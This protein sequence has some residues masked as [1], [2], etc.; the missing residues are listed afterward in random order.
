MATTKTN[1]INLPT[2]I[3]LPDAASQTGLSVDKLTRLVEAGRIAA[4]Q[5]PD[6]EI[7]VS[8]RDTD[9]AVPTPKE[10]L[11]EYKKH[12]HLR[13][14]VIGIGEA[15]RRHEIPQPTISRWVKLGYIQK[16]GQQ[17]QKLLIDAADAAYC[18]E[19]Y[20]VRGGGQG[21]WLFNSDGT[22]YTPASQ[23]KSANGTP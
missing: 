19:I 3:P 9:R 11:P 14:Q 18:A 16:L 21:R 10:E 8:R 13:G 5:L 4:A 17:G 15:A 23:N 12:A 20:R 6:G 7:V 2:F 1:G 22:P